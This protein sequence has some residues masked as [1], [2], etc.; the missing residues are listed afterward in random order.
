MSRIKRL[1]PFLLLGPISGPLV[2]G[3]VFNLREG[4]PVLA[5]LYAMALAEFT[6]LLPVVTAH[7][8]LQLVS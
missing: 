4:R 7:L 5:S 6:F 2:A 3:V 1:G 8:G